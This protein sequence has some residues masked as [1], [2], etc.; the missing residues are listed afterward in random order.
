MYLWLE[1]VLC[2]TLNPLVLPS[3]PWL[4]EFNEGCVVDGV[5]SYLSLIFQVSAVGV[6][7]NS[8]DVVVE[9]GAPKAAPQSR[10]SL[11]WRLWL[12]WWGLHCFPPGLH[13]G[14][15][16]GHLWWEP[17]SGQGL[18]LLSISRGQ[19]GTGMKLEAC[20]RGLSSPFYWVRRGY[21]QWGL[22]SCQ[23]L[24]SCSQCRLW[25]ALLSYSWGVTA[26]PQEELSFFCSHGICSYLQTMEED[27]NWNLKFY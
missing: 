20:F 6:V 1:Y 17:L 16:V 8:P 12:S 11:L 2:C 19:G 14:G 22:W 23:S 27:Q 25:A 10:D 5:V 4:C 9:E 26:P 7:Y 21:E 18:C 24:Y 13:F 3:Q 15:R